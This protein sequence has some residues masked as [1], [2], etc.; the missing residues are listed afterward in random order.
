VGLPADLWRTAPAWLPD[1]GQLDR[2]VLRA[3]GMDPAPRRAPTTWRSFL[4]RQATGI[5]ACDFFTVD[6]IW[7]RRLYVLFVIELGSRRVHLAG[8]T[9]HPT[10][11]WVAQ[12]ARN[13]MVELDDR[14]AAFRFLIRDRDTKFIRAFDDVWRSTGA[15]IICTPIRAPNANAVAERW[16]GT[17]RR[18]CL[19]HLL[20]VGR[21]HLVGVLHGYVEH[22]NQHRPH[23]SLGLGTPIPSLRADPA[24]APVVPQLR[25]R[26]ILGGL[27]HEYEWAA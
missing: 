27:V 12:Q 15:E 4:H 20:I 14:A 11:P 21:Q 10:G 17:V 6:T 24:S 19:D 2:R 18:E 26:E 16:V 9:A 25:R 3:H 22:Y 13:L 5:L 8:V 1:L 7:L 23:R